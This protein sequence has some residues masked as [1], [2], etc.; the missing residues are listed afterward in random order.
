MVKA[1]ETRDTDKRASSVLKSLDFKAQLLEEE[2]VDVTEN[3]R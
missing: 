2:K 1:T 3:R